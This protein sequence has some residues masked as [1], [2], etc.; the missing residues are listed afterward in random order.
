MITTS[1]KGVAKDL[2]SRQVSRLADSMALGVGTATEQLTDLRLDSEIVRVP[3]TSVAPDPVADRVVFKASLPA[4]LIG[5]IY[6][7]GLFF[8][9]SSVDSGRN[10]G[11]AD[12]TGSWTNATVVAGTGRA[13]TQTVK[14]DFVTSGTT[15]AELSGVSED[16]SAFANTDNVLLNFTTTAN[17]SSLRVRL[18]TD[19]ANYYEFLVSSPTTGYNIRRINISAATKV[20]NPSWAA[21]TYLAIRPSASASGGGSVNFDNLRFEFAPAATGNILVARK[22][23]ATPYVTDNEIQSE[24]EYSLG[25]NIT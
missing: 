25:V 4:G 15:N 2:F 22:I 12:V 9:E 16:L 14:I 6:E 17:L 11:L 8:E 3:I 20:G 5:T 23:L 10:L 21:V 13:N 1:G 19:S 24:V 7:V 18:G